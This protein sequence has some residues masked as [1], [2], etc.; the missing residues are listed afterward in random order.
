[1][2]Y[3]S[4]KFFATITAAISI[5]SAGLSLTACDDAVCKD[6]HN[7]VLVSTTATCT[8]N[9]TETYAC[10]DC[11][12]TKTEAVAAYGHIPQYQKSRS[13]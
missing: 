10:A 3:L 8:E 4:R 7:F 5:L 6:G 1:M 12:E 2:K 13:Q 9:G 11:G